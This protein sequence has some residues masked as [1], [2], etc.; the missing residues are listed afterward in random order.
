MNRTI[1]SVAAITLI[2]GVVGALVPPD[3]DFVRVVAFCSLAM[4]V[5]MVWVTRKIVWRALWSAT[6][7]SFAFFAIGLFLVNISLAMQ[8]TYGL[9]IRDLGKT[10]LLTSDVFGWIALWM[11]AGQ[12][13]KFAAVEG[14]GSG[15]INPRS[16]I[17]VIMTSIAAGV[18]LDVLYTLALHAS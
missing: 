5:Q 14:N 9:A 18:L 2:A 10:W 16:A 7:E 12:A 15:R 17:T 13:F 4:S 8:R 3:A 11:F 1:I 6:D